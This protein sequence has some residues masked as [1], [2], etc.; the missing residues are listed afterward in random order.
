MAEADR[1]LFRRLSTLAGGWTL[2]SA[3]AVCDPDGDAGIDVLEG[4]ASSSTPAWFAGPRHRGP[5]VRHAADR[6][7]VR[8]ER[9]EAEED[10]TA[11]ERRHAHW[12]LGLAEEAESHFRGP[13]LERWL[14]SLEVEHDNLRAALRW[15]LEEDEAE[16]GLCLVASLWRLWH[17]GGY[18]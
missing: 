14:R 2:A 18:L 9:L 17:L 5:A 12:F 4:I 6:A 10:R 1:V 3:A 16:I 8:L 15:T 13:G 11:I 7:G